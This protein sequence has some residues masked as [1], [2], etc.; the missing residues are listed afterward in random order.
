MKKKSL[1][2]LSL[3]VLGFSALAQSH[4]NI[5]MLGADYTA[6]S[7]QFRVSWNDIPGGACHNSKIWLWVDFIKIE[8]NQPSGTWTRATVADPSP[9]TV[10]PETAKGFWLQGKAGSYTQTVTVSLTNIPENTIFNWCAYAS[11]CPPNATFDNGTY[12]LHGMPPFT[13]RAAGGT[14]QTVSGITIAATALDI[15][16][17]WMTDRT[18]CPWGFCPYTASDLIVDASHVCQL[19]SSGAQNWEA[20]ITDSRDSNLYRIVFMPDKRWWMAQNLGYTGAGTPVTLAGCTPEI[21]ARYYSQHETSGSYGGSSGFGANIQGICPN[22]WVLPVTDDWKTF[23]ASISPTPSIVCRR[24]R[25]LNSACSPVEDYYGWAS[26]RK[27]SLLGY[28]DKYS[29]MFALNESNCGRVEFEHTNNKGVD[30]NVWHY[31]L[32]S[33]NPSYVIGTAVRC[34]R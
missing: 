26:R 6:P 8:N 19:R 34:L 18:E 25:A 1:S 30:C 23:F 28:G 24:L 22:G 13:L 31:D 2:F 15:S 5:E 32:C 9:G 29:E 7:V 20:W 14:P 3:M 17:V 11:D 10:A 21:C 4:I 33:V 27:I 16:P 12:T